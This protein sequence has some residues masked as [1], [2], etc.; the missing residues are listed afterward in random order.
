MDCESFFKSISP[1]S[2][3]VNKIEETGKL[4]PSEPESAFLA[5]P[6]FFGEQAAKIKR[7]RRYLGACRVELEYLDLLH[8]LMFD[9]YTV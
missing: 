4:S 6:E 2:D 9:G 8:I 5:L 1:S 3:S 7:S